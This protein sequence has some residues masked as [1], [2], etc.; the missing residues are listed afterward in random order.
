MKERAYAGDLQI[1]LGANYEQNKFLNSTSTGVFATGDMSNTNFT[2]VKYKRIL[3]DGLTFV[4]SG[5]AGY[6]Y[7]D[8]AADSYI[9]RLNT[10]V[11]KLSLL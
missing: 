11:N 3:A 6:T 9:D 2:G 7:I 4:G 5:F 1:V 8:K 10:I